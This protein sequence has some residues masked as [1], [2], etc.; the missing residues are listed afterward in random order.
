M[1]LGES[2]GIMYCKFKQVMTL[3]AGA[4]ARDFFNQVS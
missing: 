2:Q 3:N 1:G 4:I